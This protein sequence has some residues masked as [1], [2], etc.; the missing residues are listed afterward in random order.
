[1]D[2]FDR[3]VIIELNKE[4]DSLRQEYAEDYFGDEDGGIGKAA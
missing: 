2:L 3:Y 4:Q 1:M